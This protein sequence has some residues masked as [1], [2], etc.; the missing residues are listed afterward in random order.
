M[1]APVWP[2]CA[3]S[4]EKVTGGVGLL[5]LLPFAKHTAQRINRVL[6][7]LFDENIHY[8][9]LKFLYGAKNQQS[10]MRAYLRYIPVVY[11]VWHA[12]KF[13]STHT[14]RLF[15]PVP[16]FPTERSATPWFN[17]IIIPKTDTYGKSYCC[18]DACHNQDTTPALLQ[19]TDCNRNQ[20]S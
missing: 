1:Q 18:A 4:K 3:L 19:G 11:G 14:F 2:P 10:N 6:P 15:W 20:W 8:R 16:N 7:L 5:H 9:I 17:H 13:V 12:Y